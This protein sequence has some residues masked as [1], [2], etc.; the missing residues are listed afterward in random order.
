M[1]ELDRNTDNTTTPAPAQQSPS[2][3]EASLRPHSVAIIGAGRVGKLLSA[4]LV[5]SGIAVSGPHRRGEPVPDEV[6]LALICTPDSE[7][8]TVARTL[9]DT[10]MVGHCCGAHGPEL[11]AR[12]ENSL[13]MHPLMT[14]T[15]S[16][17]PEALVGAWAAVDGTDNRAVAMAEGIAHLCGMTPVRIDPEN[18]PAYHAAASVASNFLITVE[19][20]AEQIASAAGLPREA[21]LP[22][23]QASL[24]NWAKLGSADAL[25]GPVARGDEATVARQ[26]MAIQASNPGLVELFDALCKATQVLAGSGAPA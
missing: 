20:A 7:I 10:L 19:D 12:S 17:T 11:L 16:T 9:P 23:V 2:S 14:I 1:R 3:G 13:A 18:R 24:A 21:L 25:T 5:N 4:C 26:R 8:A 15:E 6:Q 22:L